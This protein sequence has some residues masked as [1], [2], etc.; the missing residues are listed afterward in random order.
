[1]LRVSSVRSLVRFIAAVVICPAW[2]FAYNLGTQKWTNSPVVMQLQLGATA[3][4]LLDGSAS[5]GASAEDALASWSAN[6]TNVKFSVVRDSTAAIALDNSLNNVFWSSTIYGDAW[7][8]RTLAITLSSYAVPRN[9]YTEADVI[10]NNTLNWNS[11]RGALRRSGGKNLYDFHRV[12]LHEFGHVLGL[13]HP[14]DISQNVSAIMNSTSGDV[15]A[16]TADDIAGAKAIYDS[17]AAV[18]A[19][20]VS[21]SGSVGYSRVGSSVTMTASSI[22]NDG[23]ATSGAL[24]LELWA[25]PTHYSNGLPT[26]SRNLGTGTVTAGPLPPN[27]QASNISVTTT[28]T[29]PP[30]GT[31]YVVM[32]LTEFTGASGTGYSIRDSLEFDGTLVVGNG[33]SSP[34]ISVQ[35][36]GQTVSPGASVS[37]TVTASGTAPLGYQWYKDGTAIV[38]ATSATLSFSSVKAADAGSYTVAVSNSAGSATSASAILAVTGSARITNLSILT[39]VD[40]PPADNFTLGYVVGN[41]SASNPLSLIIRAA[42]PALGALNYPG[43][44]ADPKFELF[45]GSTS[46]GGNND[47]GGTTALKNAFVSVGAFAYASDTSKDAAAL[48]SITTSNNSVKVSAADGGTGAVIA[49]VYDATPTGNFSATG[50]RLVNVSVLKP[51]GASLT[52]GFVIGG[53]GSKNLL[54]RASG[55]ALTAFGFP[56]GSVIADPKLTVYSGQTTIATNDTWGGGATLSAAFT[57]AGAF[58][59]SPTS[60]DAAVTA[61]LSPGAYTVV[62]TPS[63]GATGTG[64]VEVYELP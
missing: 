64:L 56:A 55:P 49:E 53:T 5:W 17:S 29:T 37:F 7:D 15:D 54:I 52:V 46:T 6:L 36:V 27:S 51:I 26:G 33:I 47:W 23:N 2:L 8:D 35:P 24:R 25:M 39:T 57:A 13:N 63:T 34:I 14:D 32:L 44:M 3:A 45:A 12:A 42:G 38:G 43:T 40:A 28:Y 58:Q 11:Y 48:T 16:L 10:F 60:L 19:S 22:R 59:F 1:M 41:P 30:S 61:T 62:V 21:I 50:P 9:N 20:A 31:Y 4:P 18:P